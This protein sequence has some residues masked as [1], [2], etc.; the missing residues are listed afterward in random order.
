M[1]RSHR[2]DDMLQLPTYMHASLL[3]PP[4]PPPLLSHLGKRVELFE[5]SVV[6]V[7]VAAVLVI[8]LSPNHI[9][10]LPVVTTRSCTGTAPIV[11]EILLTTTGKFYVHDDNVNVQL[12][13]YTAFTS[14]VPATW[15]IYH[16]GNYCELNSC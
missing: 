6:V 15:I 12:H 7:V 13:C 10:Q 5:G 1:T 16:K 8:P 14:Y 9:E 11:T 2:S 4:S 3:P